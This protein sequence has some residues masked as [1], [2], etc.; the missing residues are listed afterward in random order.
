MTR[1]RKRETKIAECRLHSGADVK[2][3]WNFD[4]EQLTALTAGTPFPQNPRELTCRACGATDA[5]SYLYRLDRNGRPIVMAP[6][7]TSPLG[8]RRGA[9][10]LD[11]L[12]NTPEDH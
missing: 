4:G 3:R 8:Y 10:S 1:T 9:L 11:R 7:R 5:G 6:G 2:K 12:A